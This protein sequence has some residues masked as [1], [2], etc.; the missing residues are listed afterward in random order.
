MSQANRPKSSD[1]S[2][3]WVAL[4][5][6]VPTVGCVIAPNKLA[7]LVLVAIVGSLAWREYA[8]NLLGRERAGLFALCLAGY[9]ATLCGAAF[10]GAEGQTAGLLV[11]LSLGA[12]YLM[13]NLSPAGDKIS[14]NL[15]ARYGLGQLYLTFCLSFVM[16]LKQ[17]DHGSNWLIFT[18]LVTAMSD[19]G[20]YLVGSRLKGPKLFPKVSPSK[21]VSGLLGGC[22]LSALAA[23]LSKGYL[24][25]L[26]SWGQLAGLGLFLALW[27]TFG[28]LF[29]S[30]FKRAMGLKDTSTLLRGHGGVWDRL[31]SLLLNLPPVYFLVNWMTAP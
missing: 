11:S 26:M 30:A 15:I 10:L 31:D 16:L 27:G 2:R 3:W 23:A 25:P 1:F 29:E 5:L 18:L 28:D 8:V 14:V 17:L 21:T 4:C 13:Y 9:L 19:T 12:A 24:P 20:A 7:L 6:I 22:A